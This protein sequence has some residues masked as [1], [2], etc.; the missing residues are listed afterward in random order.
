MEN[1]LWII[2]HVHRLE[3]LQKIL[4]N[5]E[6]FTFLESLFEVALW[7]FPEKISRVLNFDL[8]FKKELHILNTFIKIHQWL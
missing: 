7:K 5:V 8:L 1:I 2:L 6:L 3:I 4:W